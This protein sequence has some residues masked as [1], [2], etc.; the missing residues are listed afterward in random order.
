[1]LGCRYGRGERVA[2]NT[3]DGQ[4]HPAWPAMGKWL[5]ATFVLSLV[6]WSACLRIGSIGFEE[7]AY[8]FFGM[9]SLK[10]LFVSG[11]PLAGAVLLA[12]PF[13]IAERSLWSWVVLIVAARL[14]TGIAFLVSLPLSELIFGSST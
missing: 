5:A 12:I 11:T 7:V 1:M 6:Y 8:P 13:R 10:G 14:V 4:S 2:V 3:F 9:W